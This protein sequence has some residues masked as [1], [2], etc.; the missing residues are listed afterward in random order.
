MNHRISIIVP[1]YNDSKYLVKCIE[2]IIHQTY[3]N[4][5]IILI[6]DG[7]TDNSLEICQEYAKKDSRILVIHKENGGLPSARNA[8]LDV[9]NGEYVMFCDADDFYNPDSCEIL[10]R[11]ISSKCAD[12]AIGN[13]INC[14]EDGTL[15]EKPIFDIEKYPDFKLSI[16]DYEKSCREM[17]KFSEYIF[18]F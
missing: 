5:Q 11:A 12:Y 17:R 14:D 16:H 13:Y 3:T 4:L 7:S 1:I 18:Y 6:D 9:S 8:G 10:E 2:S 15:W